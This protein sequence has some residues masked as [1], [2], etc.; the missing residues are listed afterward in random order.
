[1][2]KTDKF[3]NWSFCELQNVYIQQRLLNAIKFYRLCTKLMKNLKINTRRN[4]YM[5]VFR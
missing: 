2:T 4:E 5:N 1:M 3:T